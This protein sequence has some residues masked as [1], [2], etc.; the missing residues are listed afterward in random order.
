MDDDINEYYK[1]TK[2][3]KMEKDRKLAKKEK[4]KKALIE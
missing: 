4:K 2:E 3:Y 1:Q